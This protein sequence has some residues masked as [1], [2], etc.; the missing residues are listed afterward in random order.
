VRSWIGEL[1]QPTLAVT[2][3]GVIRAVFAA[4]SGWDLRGKPPAKLDWSAVHL[5]RV[6]PGGTA[7]VER[8]NVK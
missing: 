7:R 6:G 3:R 4:A 5:F 1:N 8:L 2:H